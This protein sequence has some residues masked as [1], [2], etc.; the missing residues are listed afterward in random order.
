MEQ[1]IDTIVIDGR[2][3]SIYVTFNS[4][5]TVSFVRMQYGCAERQF[6][7]G[8]EDD[9]TTKVGMSLVRAKLAFVEIVIS[10]PAIPDTDDD[11]LLIEVFPDE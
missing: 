11:V 5:A 4:D 7:P 9:T 3:W 8:E 2:T 6:R 1:Y 10:P